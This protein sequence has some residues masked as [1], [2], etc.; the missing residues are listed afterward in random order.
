MASSLIRRASL[1]VLSLLL[2]GLPVV[3]Q[4]QPDPKDPASLQVPPAYL[5]RFRISNSNLGYLLTPIYAEGV[6]HNYIYE[7][8]M[9]SIYPLIP[10][11][12]PDPS[13]MLAPL[14]QWTVIEQGRAYTYY[15][16]YYSTVGSNYHY[17]GVRGYIFP[18][19]GPGFPIGV[20]Y[21][22]KKGFFF[23]SGPVPAGNLD[24]PVAGVGYIYQG[25]LGNGAAFALGSPGQFPAGCPTN[26]YC[27]PAPGPSVRYNPLPPPPPPPTCDPQE[28]S[29]CSLIGGI[30]YSEDCSC[31]SLSG[32]D[33][34]E[35]QTCNVNGGFWNNCMCYYN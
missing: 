28:E 17:D 27:F 4:P 12:E 32:C 10:G 26:T 23:G 16:T 31:H 22:T 20:Y 18:P 6:A 24:P 34:Y 15:S 11:F 19:D 13:S 5:F 8:Y 21:S 35:E 7:R 9:A 14:H 1:A 3:G 25:I 29:D 33:P 2:S 30:W